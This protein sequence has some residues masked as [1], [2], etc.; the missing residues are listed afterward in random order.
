MPL[1]PTLDSAGILT[2]SVVDAALAFSAIDPGCA[3][4]PAPADLSRLRFGVV[5]E[6]FEGCGRG[7]ADAVR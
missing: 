5:E 1:S 6:L 3:A 2:R 4:P 7:V